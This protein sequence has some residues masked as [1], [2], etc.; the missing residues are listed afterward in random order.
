V[1]WL[2]DAD[3]LSQPAKGKPNPRVMA[4][5]EMEK[6]DWRTVLSRRRPGNTN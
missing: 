5:L 6:N 3:I 4:W 1:S 2:L